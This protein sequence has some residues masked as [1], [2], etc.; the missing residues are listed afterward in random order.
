MTIVS[1]PARVPAGVDRLDVLV[2]GQ[3]VGDL[4]LRLCTACER[5]VIEHIRIDR[6]YRGRGL[7]RR[8]VEAATEGRRSWLWSTTE[9]ADNASAAGFA[10]AGIWPGPP[11]PQWCA[12]MR[13]AD[14]LMP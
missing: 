5:A 7:A 8:L 9:I 14:D 11:Q 3:P 2:D 4:H 1:V 6:H 12:H 13:A 10:A